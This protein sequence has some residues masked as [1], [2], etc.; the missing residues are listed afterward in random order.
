MFLFL[1]GVSCCDHLDVGNND[2]PYE[3]IRNLWTVFASFSGE[4]VSKQVGQWQ[5][6]RARVFH[7]GGH[8]IMYVDESSKDNRAHSTAQTGQ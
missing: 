3:G 5:K 8:A 1:R 4:Q 2:L 7:G 6:V